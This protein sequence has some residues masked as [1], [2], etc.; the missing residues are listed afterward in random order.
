[1]ND[2]SPDSNIGWPIW[3]LTMEYYQLLNLGVAVSLRH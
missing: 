3:T 2:D 1:M